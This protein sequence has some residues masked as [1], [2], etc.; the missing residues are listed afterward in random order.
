VSLPFD[1]LFAIKDPQEIEIIRKVANASVNVNA[2]N[3]PV[4]FSDQIP[5][6]F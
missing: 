6:Y 1:K 3:R 5:V 4:V 2:K